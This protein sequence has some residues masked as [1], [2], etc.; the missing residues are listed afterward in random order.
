MKVSDDVLRL[1][2]GLREL[3]RRTR[4]NRRHDDG[5][6]TLIAR[7]QQFAMSDD[8]DLAADA[9]IVADLE[10]ERPFGRYRIDAAD[11]ATLTAVEINGG[12]WQPGGGKHG[13]SRDRAKCRALQE[14][15]WIVLEYLTE[16]VTRDA[17]GVIADIARVIRGRR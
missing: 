9:A 3:L 12:R 14:A 4:G 6:D 1:N 16:D 5:A 13:T 15:G 8:A 10:R 2:P 17:A 11:A 7:A